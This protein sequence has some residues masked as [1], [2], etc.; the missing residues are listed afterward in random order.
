M[1]ANP[2]NGTLISSIFALF[3]QLTQ[4]RKRQLLLLLI[5]TV[6]TSVAEIIS[7]GALL[8]FL[9]LLSN[10]DII[11]FNFYLNYLNEYFNVQKDIDLV[12]VVAIIFA[13]TIILS[14][15]LKLFMLWINTKL[16]FA[17]GRDL[18]LS[19]YCLT[20]HQPYSVHLQRNSSEVIDGVINKTSAVTAV[21]M[22][23]ISIISSSFLLV[24][25]MI[26]ALVIDSRVAFL[27]FSCFGFIYASFVYSSRRRIA[28]NS[29]SISEQSVNVL[30]TLQEGIGGI[31]DIILD[32]SQNF[33]VNIFEK[34]DKLL[35]DAKAS[36]AYIS[37]Y[38]R[39]LIES[40]SMILI[41]VLAV[42]LSFTSNNFSSTIPILGALVF[43]AQ[44]ILP[45]L[46][47]IYMGLVG[48]KSYRVSL[49][50]AIKLLE[51]PITEKSSTR[52]NITFKRS[53]KFNNIYFRYADNLPI[54]LEGINLEIKKGDRIGIIGSTGGGKSTFLD[55]LMG[56][57][58]PTKGVISVDDV[59]INHENNRSWQKNISHVP[60]SIYLS[61]GSII[62]NIAFGVPKSQICLER[63]Y[64]A[65]K[66]AQIHSDISAMPCGY[67]TLIGERGIRLSGGQ[68]QRIG[69]ARAFYKGT[70]FIVL[71]EATSALDTTTEELIMEAFASLG[72]NCTLVIVA[73]RLSTLKDCTTIIE[74]GDQG[75]SRRI[76]SPALRAH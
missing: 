2:S 24:A 55:I 64:E 33:Y 13:C 37:V 16:S 30:K 42:W 6:A 74:I 43:C 48:I 5:L 68:R 10:P 20:L 29:I 62:E 8:P 34:A 26:S 27:S 72:I 40:S 57:L 15:S 53:I 35:K 51:Q 18:G 58:E 45:A 49:F 1:N 17:I 7:I 54:V 60:Q 3:L 75:I 39:I 14:G 70:S 22:D 73:H 61:D 56:L 32:G 71:D 25:V 4:K 67:E 38:P 28:N 66:L 52:L 12:V 63:I 65:A 76:P 59:N 36:N 19:I 46:Q 11:K 41:I 50:E 9:S 47:Q 31:R 69:I 44:R 21:V 23:C